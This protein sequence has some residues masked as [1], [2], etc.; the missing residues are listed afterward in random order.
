MCELLGGYGATVWPV[1]SAQEALALLDDRVPDVILSDIAM[2]SQ[3]GYMLMRA[4][5]SR[6]P[7][8]VRPGGISSNTDTS[9]SA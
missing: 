1:A 3:D 7:T 8:G 2:P 4:V 6:V 5:R 9:R